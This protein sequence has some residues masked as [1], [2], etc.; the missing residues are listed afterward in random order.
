M[1]LKIKKNSIKNLSK[2]KDQLN[3]EQTA[4]IAG[5]YLSQAWY[6]SCGP[7]SCIRK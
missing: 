2:T 7:L 3:Q 1:K 6:G 5:G 4:Q